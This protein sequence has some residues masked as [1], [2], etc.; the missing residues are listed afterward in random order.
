MTKPSTTRDRD[1]VLDHEY[2]GIKEY[3]N[4]LPGWW[5]WVFVV[6]IVFSVGYFAYYQIGPGPTIIAKYEEEMHEAA[7]RQATQTA[8]QGE[9]TDATLVALKSDRAAMEHAREIF[10]TRCAPCHG[11]DGQGVIGPN[12]T[13]EYW[14]H[15]GR[16]TEILHTITEGVLDKGMLAWKSQLNPGEL[17]AMAAYVLTLQGSHPPNPKPPQGVKVTAAPAAAPVAAVRK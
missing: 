13:D 9:V 2:D 10:T 7:E 5:V 3:D 12:L 6:S 16:P 11:H 8:A 14:L 4:P 1:R 15:G 17:R